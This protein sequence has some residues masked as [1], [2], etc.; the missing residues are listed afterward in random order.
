M[1]A[2]SPINLVQLRELA[3]HPYSRGDHSPL[4]PQPYLLID[5]RGAI[6]ADA[7]ARIAAWLSDQ[8]CPVLGIGDGANAVLA[9]CDVALTS[10][11]EAL[12]LIANIERAPIAAMTLVQ[13]L[14]ATP[15][16]PLAQGLLV[17]SLAYA[18]LQAGPEFRRWLAQP[19]A[20]PATPATD[21]PAVLID[22]AGAELAIRLNRPAR[23]NA[24][25]VEVRDALVEALQLVAADPS[26]ELARLSGNG[27]CFSIGGDLEEFGSVAD[28]ATGHAIRSLRLPAA[29]LIACAGRIECRLHSACIGAGVEIPVFAHRVV[30]ARDAFFQLPEL[31]FGLI[32]GAGGTVSLPRRIG[33]QRTA[34]L[35]LSARKINA[36]KA[37]EWGLVDAIAD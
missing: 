3:Q 2:P 12:P 8:P 10:V 34:W 6:G 37:L 21:G 17:E 18:T 24:L 27:D 29:A 13:V 25:S 1:S 31:R 22:R 20:A 16:L 19:R 33:R 15:L 26:I 32:P 7:G 5:T 14:R 28:A 11:A 30:A 4:G 35:A 23:R 36:V 9:A